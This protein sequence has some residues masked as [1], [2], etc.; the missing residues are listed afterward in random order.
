MELEVG[1]GG[2]V[3]MKKVFLSEVVVVMWS[4]LIGGTV[5]GGLG[6]EFGSDDSGGKVPGV[7]PTGVCGLA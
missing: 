5:G 7:G 1:V 3:V 4:S 6:D 2:G